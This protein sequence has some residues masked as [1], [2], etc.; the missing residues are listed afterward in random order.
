MIAP[1]HAAPNTTKATPVVDFLKAPRE[2]T[3][4]GQPQ[5]PVKEAPP[6]VIPIMVEVGKPVYGLLSDAVYISGHLRVPYIALG[7]NHSF[8]A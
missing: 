1:A 4:G 2:L 7:G 6:I 3:P 5:E 8:L